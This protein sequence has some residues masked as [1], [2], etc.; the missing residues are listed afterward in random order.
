M[1]GKATIARHPIHPMLVALPIGSFGG[2][3]IS[4]IIS[5]WGDGT[6]WPRMS[7][8]LIAFGV[9]SALGAAL[10]GFID[11]FTAPMLPKTKQTA[12]IHMIL[13]LVVVAFYIAAFFVRFATPVSALGYILTYIG[14]AL[15]IGSGWFGGELIYIE[16]V[17]PA[18]DTPEAI[19]DAGVTSPKTATVR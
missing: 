16:H 7:L 13:N 1:Q 19:S 3:L 6:F 12:T 15:L 8:W 10:F 14:L 2:V 11:Y 9:I 18:P 5:I 17:G 4:D